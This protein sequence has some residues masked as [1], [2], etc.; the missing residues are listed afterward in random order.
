[1]NLNQKNFV[2]FELLVFFILFLTGIS[3]CLPIL[4]SPTIVATM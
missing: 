1:M 3:V 2:P 4:Y